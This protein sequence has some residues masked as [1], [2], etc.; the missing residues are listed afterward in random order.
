MGPFLG[1][2]QR[3]F[4]G[5]KSSWDLGCFLGQIQWLGEPWRGISVTPDFSGH[6]L[7]Q[8]QCPRERVGGCLAGQ[9]LTNALFIGIFPLD[10]VTTTPIEGG[11]ITLATKHQLA[12]WQWLIWYDMTWFDWYML[13]KNGW[14]NE[15]ECQRRPRSTFLVL[16]NWTYRQFSAHTM[17][18]TQ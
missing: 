4:W 9:E 2:C 16:Q 15:V 10:Y 1:V 3:S 14:L 11:R 13:D 8:V 12:F 7:S 17:Q 6:H 18:Y 5:L